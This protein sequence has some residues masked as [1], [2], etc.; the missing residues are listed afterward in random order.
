[1]PGPNAVNPNLTL[2]SWG[3][4]FMA[5]LVDYGVIAVVFYVTTLWAGVWTYF[6]MLVV[7]TAFQVWNM[8]QQGLTGQTVGK[9]LVGLVLVRESD[10]QPVGPSVSIGRW[11]THIL[12]ALPCGAGYFSPLWDGRR[13]TFADKIFRT[14]VV[15]VP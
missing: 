14:V 3:R 2:A 13:Q 12:D 15:D 4:R 7:T 1:M 5:G 8:Y 9:K 10:A 11:L 6:L